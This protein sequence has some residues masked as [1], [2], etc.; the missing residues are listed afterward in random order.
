ME[1]L[2]QTFA[3]EWQSIV[4]VMAI[5]SAI[6]HVIFA[7]AVAKDA[8]K[9]TKAGVATQLVSPMTWAFATLVGGVAV[10]AVYWFIHHVN[11]ARHFYTDN[12][13]K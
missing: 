13:N 6:V 7:G 12:A 9:I 5:V 10:A 2:M 1:N 11:F 4:T 3:A 8:G